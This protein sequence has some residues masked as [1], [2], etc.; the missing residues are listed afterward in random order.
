[1]VLKPFIK[2]NVSSCFGTPYTGRINGWS[3]R[4][5]SEENLAED[6]KTTS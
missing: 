4:V 5:I 6:P 3:T 2:L 1:M